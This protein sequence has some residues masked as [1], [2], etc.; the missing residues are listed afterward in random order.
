MRNRKERLCK[1]GRFESLGNRSKVD[2]FLQL[3]RIMADMIDLAERDED[4]EYEAFCP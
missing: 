4:M 3:E 2:W 1:L